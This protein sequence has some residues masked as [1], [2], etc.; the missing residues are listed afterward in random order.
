MVMRKGL[1]HAQHVGLFRLLKAL[2]QFRATP[3]DL[4]AAD[5]VRDEPVFDGL[6]ED[7]D[8]QLALRLELQVQGQ[9]CDQGLH[10]VLDVRPGDP[11]PEPGQDLTRSLPD[12]GRVHRVDPVLDTA[13]APHVLPFHAGSEFAFLLLPRLIQRDDLQ[14]AL[15]PPVPA[16]CG[17]QAV[18]AEP[19][20]HAH[21]SRRIPG[22]VVQQ[23]LRLIGRSVPGEFR[24]TPPVTRGKI[25]HHRGQVLPDLH[26]CLDPPETWP[27]QP[28]Q[29][30]PFPSRGSRAYPGFRSR[31]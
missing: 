3:V 1:R 25:A 22:R 30:V 15:P 21:R 10:R 29:L 2:P 13:R 4:V 9:G 6:V 12:P 17:L 20:H 19:A 31:L 24:D 18:R 11:L 5:E 27:Q 23:P 28:Q 14:P 16:G 7:P 26:K 8:G